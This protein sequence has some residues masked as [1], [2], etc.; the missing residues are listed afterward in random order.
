M[1][2]QVKLFLRQSRFVNGNV[3]KTKASQL[4]SNSNQIV[5]IVS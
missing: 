5:F 3:E 4:T 1:I 2:G